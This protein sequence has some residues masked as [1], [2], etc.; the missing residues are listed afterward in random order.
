M[1]ISPTGPIRTP[2][3]AAQVD[4]SRAASH[5]SQL[6]LAA[7]ARMPALPSG[8]VQRLCNSIARM[9]TDIVARHGGET[10]AGAQVQR[11][12]GVEYLLAELVQELAGPDAMDRIHKA[13]DEALV[14]QSGKPF[15]LAG[16]Q[17]GG[18][19]APPAGLT[20]ITDGMAGVQHINHQEGNPS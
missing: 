1:P 18:H 19:A 14:P 8:R 5:Y 10:S 12:L 15:F 20:S 16:R 9:R 2:N 4:R 13:L 3:E 7:Q 6:A 11:R 17:P